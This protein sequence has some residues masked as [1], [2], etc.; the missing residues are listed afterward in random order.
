[1]KIEWIKKDAIVDYFGETKKI[2]QGEI[3]KAI[4][5]EHYDKQYLVEFQGMR[6]YAMEDSQFKFIKRLTEKP[7]YN[8]R[9]GWYQ[10]SMMNETR[11]DKDGYKLK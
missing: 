4:A 2:K 7:V 9:K 8:T 5:K 11:T 10:V 6:F 1:M 3:G